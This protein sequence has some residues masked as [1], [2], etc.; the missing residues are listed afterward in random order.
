[1]TKFVQKF[2]LLVSGDPGDS[3]GQAC[4][5]DVNLFR[6]ILVENF[7]LD[8]RCIT[9]LEDANGATSRETLFT[10]LTNIATALNE[11]QSEKTLL[12][13]Q[14][15]GHGFNVNIPN[16]VGEAI[17][18]SDGFVTNQDLHDKLIS[19]LGAHVTVFAFFDACHSEQMFSLPYTWNAQ[20]KVW[21]KVENSDPTPILCS[22]YTLSACLD[23]Q[24]DQQVIGD[25]YGFGGAL[26]VG[27][28]EKVVPQ[29]HSLEDLIDKCTSVVDIIANYIKD[30]GQKPILCSN[31]G[32]NHY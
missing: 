13:V 1:M 22:A 21:T 30:L 27:F 15:S 20:Y 29:L 4:E 26:T 7:G 25:V 10:T 31:K 24:T 17:L 2:A 11:K 9:I 19:K 28:A 6:T 8:N 32:M 5:R 3:L 18:T 14:Y 12:V 16:E 23:G